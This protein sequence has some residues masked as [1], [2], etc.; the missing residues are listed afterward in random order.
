MRWGVY[1]KLEGRAIV[2]RHA[3]GSL[4]S[5]ATEAEAQQICRELDA[6]KLSSWTHHPFP[7]EV[8]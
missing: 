3:D 6:M 8:T 1:M 4:W 7:I 5:L 2:C